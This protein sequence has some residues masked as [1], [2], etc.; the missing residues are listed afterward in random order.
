ML[1]HTHSPSMHPMSLICAYVHAGPSDV[2]NS[3]KSSGTNRPTA[4]IG[5]FL[6]LFTWAHYVPLAR[7]RVGTLLRARARVFSLCKLSYQNTALSCVVLLWLDHSSI[8]FLA[9]LPSLSLSLEHTWYW[10]CLPT[11]PLHLSYAP[12]NTG[13]IFAFDETGAVLFHTAVPF[14][15]TCSQSIQKEMYMHF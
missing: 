2:R 7:A 3:I 9:S 4:G 15:A 1:A 6:S 11:P 13:A 12:P 14:C 8:A 5:V 10:L